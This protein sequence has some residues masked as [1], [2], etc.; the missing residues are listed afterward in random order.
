MKNE[1]FQ[2]ITEL[3]NFYGVKTLGDLGRAFYDETDFGVSTTFLAACNPKER[4][5]HYEDESYAVNRKLPNIWAGH[6][7]TGIRFSTIVEGSDAEYSATPLNFPIT[8]SEIQ[9]AY[10]YLGEL[11]DE[12][13]EDWSED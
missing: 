5:I 8:L 1:T 9:E 10:D 11:V 6:F 7:C 2:S 4:E 12:E 3:A 13:F